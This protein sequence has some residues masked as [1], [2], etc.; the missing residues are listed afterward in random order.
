MT[1]FAVMNGDEIFDTFEALSQDFPIASQVFLYS[2]I[3]LFMY[4]VLNVFIAIIEE[5]YFATTTSKRV[6]EYFSKVQSATEQ[7]DLSTRQQQERFAEQFE[8]LIQALEKD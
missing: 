6:L 5:A 3:A 4:V 1:L 7:S 8:Q 2:F